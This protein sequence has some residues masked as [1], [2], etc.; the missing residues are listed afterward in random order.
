MSTE[1]FRPLPLLRELLL[2]EEKIVEYYNKKHKY[3]FENNI[4]LKGF[5]FRSKIHPI[6]LKLVEL[7]R[8][9]VEKQNLTILKDLRE[10]GERPVIFCY[11]HICLY[12]FQIFCEAIRTHH[13]VL[14]GDPDT[15]YRSFDGFLFTLNG[16]VF[17]DTNSKQ[18][19]FIATERAKEI[20][21][22]GEN[23]TIAPEGVWNISGNL[24]VLPLYSGA[25]KIAMETGC[26][27]VPVGVAQD[28]KNF[29]I[30]IGENFKV[31]PNNAF[32]AVDEFKLFEEQKKEDLRNTLATLKWEIIEQGSVLKRDSLGD[33]ETEYKK[34]VSE[35]LDEWKNPKT[36]EN[37][38]SEELVKQRTFK[39]KNVTTYKMAF[40]H[41]EKIKPN[42][43]NAFLFDKRLI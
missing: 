34:Y 42:K 6:L 25:I 30:N 18:D 7:N 12:D 39:P 35:I 21:R 41:L 14:A 28:G 1:D 43:N 27:I 24:L 37:Y 20:L 9:Y 5:K 4:P 26:D 8:K 38:Y 32:Q 33:Y 17:C 23:L 40:E 36:K 16:A 2:K 22:K 11:T 29:F 15:M 31:I 3:K 13:Y 19:R 10:Q